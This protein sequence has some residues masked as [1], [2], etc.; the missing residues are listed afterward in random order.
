MPNTYIIYENFCVGGADEPYR[1]TEPEVVANLSAAL[2]DSDLDAELFAA[3]KASPTL[4]QLVQLHGDERH[5]G[6]IVFDVTRRGC[7]PSSISI[8]PIA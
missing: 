1:L 5:G 7:L 2:L 4:Q 3:T 6:I 8:E